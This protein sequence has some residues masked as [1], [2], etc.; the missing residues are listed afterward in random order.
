[1]VQVGFGG[2]RAL[3]YLSRPAPKDSSDG[4][5]LKENRR[6]GGEEG[7]GEGRSE[8]GGVRPRGEV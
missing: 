5:L 4:D 1:M 8:K 2:N 3:E 6:E 7:G